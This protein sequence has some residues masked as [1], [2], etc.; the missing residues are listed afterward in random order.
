MYEWAD[1]I[2]VGTNATRVAVNNQM[3]LLLGRGERPENGDKVIQRLKN[4]NNWCA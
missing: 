2:L 1:Q 3:R 4:E